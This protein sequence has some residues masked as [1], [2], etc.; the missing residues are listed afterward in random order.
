MKVWINDRFDSYRMKMREIAQKKDKNIN[1]LKYVRLSVF[2]FW[3]INIFSDIYWHLFFF[4]GGYFNCHQSII[5]RFK[6]PLG[7]NLIWSC[8]LIQMSVINEQIIPNQINV[9]FSLS[10]NTENFNNV[11]CN[12]PWFNRAC[13]T[14]RRN[15]I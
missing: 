2:R 4:I 15:F 13:R 1:S 7:H 14:A 8:N 12:K 5:Q 9:I 10:L 3:S 6:T 11:N